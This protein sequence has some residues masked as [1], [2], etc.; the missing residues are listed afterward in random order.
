M[1]QVKKVLQIK[2]RKLGNWEP[3]RKR[4]EK[5]QVENICKHA[6]KR[7]HRNKLQHIQYLRGLTINFILLLAKML[8]LSA[9]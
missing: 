2:H 7:Q 9:Q 1:H 5:E 8:H 4:A 6:V 3:I